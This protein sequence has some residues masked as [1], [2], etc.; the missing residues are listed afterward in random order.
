MASQGMHVKN[1]VSTVCSE[2]REQVNNLMATAFESCAERSSLCCS[3]MYSK[4]GAW[5]PHPLILNFSE[6]M[7]K[8]LTLK[9]VSLRCREQE[10]GLKLKCKVEEAL[11]LDT[12]K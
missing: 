3:L 9:L 4:V 7:T 2:A 10:G 6:N 1:K 8:K 11:S 5:N 12:N